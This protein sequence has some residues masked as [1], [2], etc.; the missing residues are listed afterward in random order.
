MDKLLENYGVSSNR[1][2][3]EVFLIKRN[4]RKEV[5]DD[6]R[7]YLGINI[8]A[9]SYVFGGWRGTFNRTYDSLSLIL[10]HIRENIR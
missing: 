8:C 5:Q 7:C 10:R 2:T 4:V 3:T 6:Q 1:N 9:L